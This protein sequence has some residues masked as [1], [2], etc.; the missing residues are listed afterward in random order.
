MYGRVVAR[1]P[2][3]RHTILREQ[4]SFDLEGQPQDTGILGPVGRITRAVHPTEKTNSTSQVMVFFNVGRET[5]SSDMA[6]PMVVSTVQ[7]QVH[8]QCP[9]LSRGIRSKTV[10]Q[11]HGCFIYRFGRWFP[12]ALRN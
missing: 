4:G 9:K 11:P 7:S 8:A 6:S 2:W 1:S 3:P 12:L 10:R 5:F